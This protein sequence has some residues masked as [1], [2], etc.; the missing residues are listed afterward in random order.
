MHDATAMSSGKNPIT[1]NSL[2]PFPRLLIEIN[3]AAEPQKSGI[4][5]A[6]LPVLLKVAQQHQLPIVG[7]MAIPPTGQPPLPYFQRLAALASDYGLPELSMGMSADWRFAIAA[8]ATMIR[9][10][11]AIFG[12]RR[13]NAVD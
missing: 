11:T 9:L 6:D 8:G 10:G 7:L 2:P 5:V 4:W 12:E 1:E 3:L 13:I